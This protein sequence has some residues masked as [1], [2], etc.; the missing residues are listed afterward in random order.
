MQGRADERAAI[1]GWLQA[2]AKDDP[3][4]TWSAALSWAATTLSNIVP[5][6]TVD[7]LTVRPMDATDQPISGE[8]KEA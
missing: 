8:E 3:V 7:G 6:S 1:I 2:E 4:A 5:T